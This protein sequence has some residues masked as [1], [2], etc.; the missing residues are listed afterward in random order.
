[1]I[2]CEKCRSQFTA[3]RNVGYPGHCDPPGSLLV[4][5][6]VFGIVAVLCGS[7]ALFMFRNVMLA[8]AAAFLFGALASLGR[9]PESCRVCEQSGG[10]NCPACGH[11]NKITWRS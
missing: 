3:D 4:Y 6:A 1:M 10:G 2:T 11:E 5:A 9:I 8:L 7:V